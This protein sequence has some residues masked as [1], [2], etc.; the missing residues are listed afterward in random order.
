MNT[1]KK[2]CPNV[3]VAQCEDKQEKG[4]TI[5]VETKYGKKNEH[6]VHNC[7]GYV[8]NEG[9]KFYWYSIT[10]SDGFDNKARAKKKVENLN[11]YADNAKNRSDEWLEKSNEG[12]DF[13][14]LGEPIKIGHH[15]ENRHRAL[16]ER[17]HKRFDNAMSEL[18]KE[19]AYRNRIDY[20]ESLA[21]KIDLSMPES[22]E[23]F[24][25]QLAEAEEYHKFL[26]DNR[27]SRPHAMG[28]SYAKKKVN[29]LT[30]KNNLAIRLWA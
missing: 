28:L 5:I 19:K 21:N 26:K 13:L 30:K 4:S 27:K 23:V 22:L 9:K 3:F 8:E 16:I 17:R 7:L 6:L 20:W 14:S 12:R 11:R 15:S 24:P 25:I 18:D 10:R 2:F 29:E 1:Y